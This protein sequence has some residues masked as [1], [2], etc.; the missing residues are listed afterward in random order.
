M[1]SLNIIVDEIVENTSQN[2]DIFKLVDQDN[3]SAEEQ[4]EDPL[5]IV[6]T[7][8][9]YQIIKRM[10]IDYLVKAEIVSP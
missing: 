2:G 4:E 7:P 5:E 8:S 6:K 9:I 3:L 10:K 1:D